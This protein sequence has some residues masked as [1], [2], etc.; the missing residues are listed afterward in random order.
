MLRL[1][2]AYEGLIE[3]LPNHIFI[4]LRLEEYVSVGELSKEELNI[5]KMCRCHEY[6][7]MLYLLSKNNRHTV[8]KSCA[9]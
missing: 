6:T 7:N 3:I 9:P 2:V 4:I 1:M 5:K 8:F